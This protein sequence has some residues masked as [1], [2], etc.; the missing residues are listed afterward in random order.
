MIANKTIMIKFLQQNNNSS[1]YFKINHEKTNFVEHFLLKGIK[2]L[3]FN[4]ID[5]QNIADKLQNTN[6]LLG[7]R[8]RNIYID[9]N[10]FF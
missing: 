9:F 4:I 8:F 3:H 7:I 5:I 10:N 2:K 6:I 1:N